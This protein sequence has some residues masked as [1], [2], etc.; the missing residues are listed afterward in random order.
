M[1][2]TAAELLEVSDRVTVSR[3]VCEILRFLKDPKDDENLDVS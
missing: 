1:Q 3:K 2:G